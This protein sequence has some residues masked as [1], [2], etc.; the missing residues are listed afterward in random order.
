MNQLPILILHVLAMSVG[1]GAASTTDFL[2]FKFLKDLRISKKEA[3][4]LKHVSHL[5]WIVLV[6]VVISGAILYFPQAEVLNHT[7]KFLIKMIV[8]SVIILN[9]VLLHFLIQPKLIHI[10]FHQKHKHHAGE[11][12]RLRKLAFMS[13]SVS[14]VSWYGT[15]VFAMLP[16]DF[17]IGL[18]G[19]L[20]IYVLCLIIGITLSLLVESYY[21]NLGK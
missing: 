18:L 10:S 8:V 20:G 3:S 6:I 17:V 14:M 2:F 21:R 7:P 16:R 13:G 19:L 1:V 9:G 11:L 15:V 5:I 4:V 12:L